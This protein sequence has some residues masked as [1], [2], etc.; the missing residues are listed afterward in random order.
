MIE[1]RRQRLPSVTV[2]RSVV[3][4]IQAS[5]RYQYY[6][7]DLDS[8]KLCSRRIAKKTQEEGE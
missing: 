2:T 6:V 1:V 5:A 7:L 4:D 8:V 3:S